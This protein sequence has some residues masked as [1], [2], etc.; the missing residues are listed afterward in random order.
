MYGHT[1]VRRSLRRGADQNQRSGRGWGAGRDVEAAR[2]DGESGQASITVLLMLA[3]FLLAVMAFAVDM[4]NMW[5][6]RQAVQTAADAACQAGA[7][8]M[9]TV[10]GGVPDL[11][12]GFVPGTASNC[13][14]SST[15]SICKYAGFN[16]YSGSGFSSTSASNSVSWTFPGSV[17]GATAPASSVTEYPYLDVTVMENVKTWFMG[18]LGVKYQAVSASCTCGLMEVESAAPM[19][20][21]NPTAAGTLTYGGGGNITI[22]GG[23]QR[24]IQINSANPLAVVCLP[25]GTLDTSAAGPNGT[26]GDIGVTGGPTTPPA[27]CYGGGVGNTGYNGGTT[28]VWRSPTAVT[29][30][31]YG[32]VPAPTMPAAATTA[33]APHV[34]SYGQDGCPDH[35]PTNYVSSVPHSGC[36]EY[37]PGYYANGISQS[38]NDVV[39]LKPGIYYM[40]SSLT[41]GGSDD[42]RLATP[43]VPSCSAYSTTSWQ[44]TDGVLLYF[45]GGGF[46]VTGGSG[47]LS[48]SRVDPVPSTQL[49]CNGSTPNASLGVSSSLNG[50]VLVAQCSTLG[51]YVGAG[52]TDT[53]S[54]SGSRGLLVFLAHSN[55][56]TASIFSGSGSLA[57]T[58]SMYYH[59]SSYGDVFSVTGG[60]SSATLVLG[61]VVADEINVTESGNIK[62]ALTQGSS[63]S[64][65][66]A[67]ILQ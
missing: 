48:S 43:C 12:M 60:A 1:E 42:I 2:M 32:N 26:G 18:M 29:P 6:H 59:S 27:T 56:Q 46:Y 33:T 49:S 40:G 58:G 36:Y 39:I 63:Q 13:V 37:E 16:G 14:T 47:Q 19:V 62:M 57:F 11:T 52:S 31:P 51:T 22:V 9:L 10:A 20:V 54:T 67:G 55:T 35:S 4:T 66:K 41:I 15:A 17:A 50:N 28:G 34:V 53:A 3:T 5:F 8:D 30:D 38:G 44:Q 64:V 24:T 21:L 23:P 25:S 65:L 7:M 61:E 45:A